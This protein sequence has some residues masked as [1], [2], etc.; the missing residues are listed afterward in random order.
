MTMNQRLVGYCER[1][2][3]KFAVDAAAGLTRAELIT[4]YIDRKMNQFGVTDEELR[5]TVTTMFR[6]R[7]NNMFTCCDMV[8]FRHVVVQFWDKYSG[9]SIEILY[10][11]LHFLQYLNS[12]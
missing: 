11:I 10:E 12:I 1:L 3:A 9:Q 6:R 8:R 4:R 2:N 7:Y 5:Q